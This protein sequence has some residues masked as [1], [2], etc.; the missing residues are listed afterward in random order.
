[1]PFKQ[2]TVNPIFV[3]LSNATSVALKLAMKIISVN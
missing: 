1:M 2:A 3:A